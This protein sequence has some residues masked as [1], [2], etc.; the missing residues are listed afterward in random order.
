MDK[1]TKDSAQKLQEKAEKDFKQS[2]FFK[3]TV[4]HIQANAS[5]GRNFIN[6]IPNRNQNF[7][8]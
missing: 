5:E 1:I 7:L 3:Q 6:I 8:K 4:E 2:R